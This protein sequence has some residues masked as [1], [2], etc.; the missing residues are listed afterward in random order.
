MKVYNIYYNQRRINNKPLT[1][2]DV[3]KIKTQNTIHKAGRG[4]LEEIPVSKVQ[5]VECTVF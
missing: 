3:T 4:Q 5:F 1:N 2:D